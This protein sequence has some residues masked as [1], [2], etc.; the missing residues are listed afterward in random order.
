MREKVAP[1]DAVGVT[2]E[3]MGKNGLLLVSGELGNPMTI[4]WGTVG[5]VWGK[6]IF[7]VL[8][9]PSRYSFRFMEHTP[10]FTVNVLEETYAEQIALCGSR[11]G[12]E[13]N[14]IDV[15]GFTLEK[16]HVVRVPF[17]AESLLH[18]ECRTV[19]KNSVI[20]AD[21][22]REIVGVYYPEGD[23]HRVYFGEILGVYKR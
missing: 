21:L 2:M 5:I 10:E 15:C 7:I 19:H 22:D 6:P 11:S 23:F 20:D 1:F 16:G 17:I 13:I 18:Y 4:G 3:H 8:V 9:R 14:K 12:R